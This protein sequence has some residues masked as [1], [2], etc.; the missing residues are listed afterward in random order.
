MSYNPYNEEAGNAHG[1]NNYE[2]NHFPATETGHEDFFTK[3]QIIKDDIEDY[4]DLINQLEKFQ[5]SALNCSSVEE[6]QTIKHKIDSITLNLKS[7]QFN[8]IKPKLV[9]LFNNYG[10]N[11]DFEDQIENVRNQF[12]KAIQKFTKVDES[13]R[14]SNQNKAIEQYQIVNPS[15]TYNESLQFVNQVGN[16]QV[17]DEAIQM[18]NRKGEAIAVLDEVKVRHQE[19]LRAVQM[20]VEL[21]ELLNDLQELTFQQDQLLDSANENINKAQNQMEKGQANVVKA[22]EHAKSGRKWKWI[23][24]W[25]VVV[26]ICAIVGGVVGGVVGSRH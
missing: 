14:Q 22:V 6:L 12:R 21:N 20:S 8:E 11:K 24:F 13:Y 15:A 18:A 1:G 7:A 26:L 3:I 5:V 9:E 16:E 10:G 4:N 17:F 19:V 23:L 2:M 25:I